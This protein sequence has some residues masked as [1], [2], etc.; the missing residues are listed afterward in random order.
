MALRRLKKS[1]RVTIINNTDQP[2]FVGVRTAGG[3]GFWLA[4]AG[5]EDGL[6]RWTGSVDVF[7]RKSKAA[8]EAIAASGAFTVTYDSR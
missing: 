8:L 7:S 1:V 2:R 4:P 6:D 5:D 3:N